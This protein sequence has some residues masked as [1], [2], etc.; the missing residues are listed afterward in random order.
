MISKEA[1]NHLYTEEKLSVA[2]VANELN[3]SEGAVNWWINKH[4]IIKRNKVDAAYVQHNK[5]F[6]I[7]TINSLE[8]MFLMG[9]GL[10][11]YWGE[12]N[13]TSPY[14]LRLGNT[15]PIMIKIFVKFLINICGVNS[16][17]IKYGLQ[18][19]N[20]ASPKTCLQYWMKE[21]NCER[22]KFHNIISV[23]PPQG[24]GTYKRKNKKGVLQIYVNNK[25]LKNWISTEINNCAD[26][27]QW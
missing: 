27:A 24:K 15:D 12:G 21:L 3:V 22:T 19:F 2:K 6:H 13:K 11:L 4:G 18:I 10:G 8:D 5:S 26:I 25:R 23:I 9:L 20:D 17:E 14:S 1:L 16:N 7:S